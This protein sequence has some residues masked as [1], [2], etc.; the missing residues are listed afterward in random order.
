MADLIKSLSPILHLGTD[1][2]VRPMTIRKPDQHSLTPG[3][4]QFPGKFFPAPPPPRCPDSNPNIQ[5]RKLVLK[6]NK[7]RCFQNPEFSKS[8][9]GGSERQL[10]A[11]F[12][13]LYTGHTL[14]RGRTAL[15]GPGPASAQKPRAAAAAGPPR[16]PNSVRCATTG[17]GLC[18]S[19]EKARLR[20]VSGAPRSA[21]DRNYVVT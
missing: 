21:S 2:W 14:P 9:A 1:Y 7:K 8:R 17:Q 13:H 3:L 4:L 18:G 16:S 5:E 19:A 15:G 10:A 6:Q 11:T 20:A 12:S